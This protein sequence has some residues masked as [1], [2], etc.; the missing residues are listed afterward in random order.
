MRISSVLL[1]VCLLAAADPAPAVTYQSCSIEPPAPSREFRAAWIATVANIDW[2]SRK[3]LTTA[4]QKAELVALLDAAVRLNL[5]AV[6]FQV[7][8]ACDALYASRLEPWSEYLTGSMGKAPT[9]YYDPLTFAIEEA[10]RRGIELHAWF[11]PYR[12]LHFSAKSP[13][14]ASHISHTHPEWVRQYG[15]L[16]WLDPGEKS[17]QDYSLSVVMDV[18]NRYD[19]DGIHF[20]D[21]FYPYKEHD[22]RGNELDFPDRQSWT[23]LGPHPKLSRED[24]RRDNVNQF[25]ARVYQSIKSSKPW[26]KFGISPF[27][28]WRPGNPPAIDGLDAYDRL[29][30]DSR[31]WLASG[32][33]DYFAP[34]LYWPIES[35]KQSFPVLLKW[36]GQQNTRHRLLVPGLDDTRVRGS[37]KPEQIVNQIRLTRQQA[38]AGGEVHWDLRNLALNTNLTAALAREAY[39]QAALVPAMPWLSRSRPAKPSLSAVAG[40]RPGEVHVTWTAVSKEAPA[41]W[42]CQARSQGEWKTEILPAEVVGWRFRSPPE[43]VCVCAVDRYGNSSAVAGMRRQP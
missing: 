43:Y 28:I 41:H 34:Q 42:V 31:K 33:V 37:Q 39:P 18:L 26:V 2:P 13:V 4:E 40:E 29:Y 32:W 3:D 16:E 38:G 19:V 15:R 21:Y 12:A 25:I 8:P 11:N 9:P 30:A 5:N 35:P 1:T 24:W 22:A 6:I 36:W 27:G 10:H 23:R 20:D 14:V 7:R 17:V